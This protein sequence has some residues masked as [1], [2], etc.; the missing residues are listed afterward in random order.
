M[1]WYTRN[2]SGEALKQS[3]SLNTIILFIFSIGLVIGVAWGIFQFV[4]TNVSG[5]GFFIQWISLRSLV[6]DGINP[7]SGEVTSRIQETV[8]Y[9]NSFAQGNPPRYTSPLYSG[10][11]IFLFALIENNLIAHTLWLTAQLIAIFILLILSLKLTSWKPAWYIFFIFSLITVFSY[12]VLIPWLDG[13]ISIWAALFLLVAFL[14]IRNNWNEVGGI[15]L[16]LATIQPQMTILVIVFALLWI[17][18]QKKR[19]LVVWFF[20]TLIFLFIIGLFLDP[21][22]IMH[23]LRLL[24]NFSENFP[25]GNPGMLFRELW[26]GLGKQL[27]WLMTGVSG[28]ILI[29]EWL[30]AFKKGFRWFLWTACL[31]IVIS[32]WIG[33]PTIPGNFTGLILPLFLVSAMLTERWPQRGQWMAVLIS[34][35]LFVWEWVLLY[36]D[37][38]SSEPTMQLN[39]IIPLPLILLIGLFWVRWWAIKPKRLLIEELRLGE[40]Y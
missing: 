39:L 34:A 38:Y 35:V 1:T 15:F 23:Y 2:K 36:N 20:M 10:L 9:E 40:T 29:I 33:I 32:Q 28:I 30:I 31:T 4:K 13:G 24:Y 12:H 18:S 27:G 25:P 14:A 6:A 5:E 19:L 3:P 7:Y 16:G 22:W 21:D 8:K 11:V 17:A 37:L 26:P